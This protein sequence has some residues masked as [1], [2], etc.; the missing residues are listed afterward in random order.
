MIKVDLN[1]EIQYLANIKAA[2]DQI[3][4][5]GSDAPTFASVQQ[6]LENLAKALDE[7]QKDLNKQLEA[8]DKPN[9]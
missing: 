9:A 3:S 2:L 1:G 4:I 7:K 6:A 5:K 8:A